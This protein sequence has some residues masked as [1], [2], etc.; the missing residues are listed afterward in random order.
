MHGEH[1]EHGHQPVGQER[2]QALELHGRIAQAAGPQGHIDVGEQEGPLQA[3]EGP[4]PAR[5]PPVGDGLQGAADLLDLPVGGGGP[6]RHADDSEPGQ[7]VQVQLLLGFHV[8]GRLAGMAGH[9]VEPLGVAALFA[10]HHH[11]GLHLGRQALDFGLALFGGVADR[12]EDLV[13][14]DFGRR[15]GLDGLV[16]ARVLGGL[17][18]DDGL[19]EDGQLPELLQGGR[20]VAPVAGIALEADDLGVVPVPDDDRGVALGR[21]LANDGLH[22]DDPGAGGVD[23]V[24]AGGAQ[25]LLGLGGDAVGADQ[26]RAGPRRGD[27]V[28]DRDALLLEEFEHL[29]IVNQGAVG[30]DGPLLFV[31]GF[32]HHLHGP[33]HTH[34]EAGGFGDQDFHALT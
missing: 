31:R 14:G 24:E 10:A 27:S 12:I 22:A 34:A 1:V 28:A 7:R 17:G 33:A 11:H 30:A 8:E 23:D 20:H 32:E 29:G 3:V 18:H 25:P 4:A 26:N 5:D 21:V 16:E 2:V 9:L 13:M 15:P 19:F 6:G